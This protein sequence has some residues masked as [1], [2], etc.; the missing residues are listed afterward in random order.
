MSQKQCIQPWAMPIGHNLSNRYRSNHC[1]CLIYINC[2]K[3]NGDML[4]IFRHK[5]G[6]PLQRC[7]AAQLQSYSQ[8]V[9]ANRA[10]VGV[11]NGLS[12]HKTPFAACCFVAFYIVKVL[13]MATT[14]SPCWLASAF[15]ACIRHATLRKWSNIIGKHLICLL[16]G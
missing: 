13:L 16:S 12:P 11:T 5:Q 6:P 9:E 15:Y 14:A 3:S 1:Y 8:K 10:K 4:S 7:Q 2:I